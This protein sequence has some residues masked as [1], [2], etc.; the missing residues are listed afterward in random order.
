MT[1]KNQK[2]EAVQAMVG[3]NIEHYRLLQKKTP[4]E[5][6]TALGITEVAYRNIE[7]GISELSLNK[8]IQIAHILQVHHSQ[9]LDIDKSQIYNVSNP[10]QSKFFY[11]QSYNN[12]LAEGYKSAIE[13]YKAENNFLRKQNREL[14]AVLKELKK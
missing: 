6:A 5:M 14:M 4:K 9:I 3:Q 8:I 2:E 13:Q 12:D 7:R 11:Q 1:K 10:T